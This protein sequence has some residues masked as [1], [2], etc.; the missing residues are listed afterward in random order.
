MKMKKTIEELQKELKTLE[1]QRKTE[2]NKTELIIKINREKQLIKQHKAT[3]SI[4][5]FVKLPKLGF[6]DEVKKR[7]KDKANEK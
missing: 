1:E 2:T 5:R 6:V 4:F 7:I 3:R